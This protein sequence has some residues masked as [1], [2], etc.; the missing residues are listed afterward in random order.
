MKKLCELIFANAKE[1]A[2]A[3]VKEYEKENG[4]IPLDEEALYRK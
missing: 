4:S 2:Q 1:K 3:Y